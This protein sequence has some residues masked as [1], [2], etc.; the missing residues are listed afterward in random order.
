MIDRRWFQQEI[1]TV[2]E[3]QVST[4]TELTGFAAILKKLI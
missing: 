2:S 1:D 4:A 3:I